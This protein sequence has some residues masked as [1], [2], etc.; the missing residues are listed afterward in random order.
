MSTLEDA[1]DEIRKAESIIGETY[2][3]VKD[4]KLYIS[5]IRKVNIILSKLLKEILS[6]KDFA[7]LSRLASA[8]EG[9]RDV[10][11]RFSKY[12]D[13]VKKSIDA[14]AKSIMILN[15]HSNSIMVFF[16]KDKLVLAGETFEIVSVS[17]K[18]VNSM[19]KD[20]KKLYSK[21]YEDKK[22]KKA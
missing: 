14:Y 7:R 22:W 10:S 15:A 4:N 2:S 18:D 19:L 6:E 5:A 8:Y 20:A 21:V 1:L 12:D 16:R 9:K 3:I 17:K 13:T 11:E